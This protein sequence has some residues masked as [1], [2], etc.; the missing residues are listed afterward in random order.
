MAADSSPSRS[1]VVRIAAASSSVTTNIPQAW[2]SRLCMQAPT[3][4][5]AVM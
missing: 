4:K 3:G 2:E 5:P 1:N